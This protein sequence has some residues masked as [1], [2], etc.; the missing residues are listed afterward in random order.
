MKITLTFNQRQAQVLMSALDF[1]ALFLFIIGF[2]SLTC[3]FGVVDGF[4][5]V[6]LVCINTLAWGLFGK[7][8]KVE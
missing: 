1:F 8:V 2:I 6:M 3:L 4:I 7:A 5:P